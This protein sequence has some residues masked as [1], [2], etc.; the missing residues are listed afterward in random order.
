MIASKRLC[1]ERLG[2]PVQT[3]L[4]HQVSWRNPAELSLKEVGWREL[5]G[6]LVQTYRSWGPW[7]VA[8]LL[9]GQIPDQ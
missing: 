5:G 6:I 8:S 1:A 9:E 7:G 2:S 3:E 4:L